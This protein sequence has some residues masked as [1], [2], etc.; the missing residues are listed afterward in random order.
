[1]IVSSVN[2]AL[3]RASLTL[4]SVI[5]RPNEEIALQ[6]TPLKRFTWLLHNMDNRNK[7]KEIDYFEKLFCRKKTCKKLI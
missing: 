4:H 2:R 5:M 7:K 1:V 3:S 6:R